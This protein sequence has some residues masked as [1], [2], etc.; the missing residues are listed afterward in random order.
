ME[1]RICSVCG[2]PATYG[3][4]LTWALCSKHNFEAKLP[5]EKIVEAQE[6][7][8]MGPSV[9]HQTIEGLTSVIMPVYNVDF[10]LLHYTGHALG[11]IR[12]FAG[13]N[14]IEIIIVD[15]ASP[16]GM[17]PEDWHCDKLIQNTE[18][19]GYV[20]AVNQGIRAAFGEYI[21]ILTTDIQ[22]YEHWLDDAKEALQHVD[23]VYG[24]PM[25]GEVFARMV[26]AKNHREKWLDKPVE[27]SLNNDVKDGACVVTTKKMFDNL[28]ELYDERFMNYAADVDLYRRM[29]EKGLK[30]AG[31]E[32]LRIFHISHATGFHVEGDAE[33]MNVDKA[34]YAEKWDKNPDSQ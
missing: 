7:K 23:L 16:I 25:Y 9:P 3:D 22:V 4:G 30:Y 31:S 18:N 13:D 8:P 14:P 20:K 6:D 1:L 12:Y 32:R 19:L 29:E 17:R 33:Q 24:K 10:P 5:E 21:A 15:N 26:E 28:G 34:A 11:S 2:E 27:D